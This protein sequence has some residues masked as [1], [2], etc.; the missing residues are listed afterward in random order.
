MSARHLLLF[1]NDYRGLSG[2]VT[3]VALV[4]LLHMIQPLPALAVPALENESVVVGEVL[5]RDIVYS[6]TLKIQPPQRLV[7]LKL[8]IVS[9]D[10]VAGADN[11]LGGQEGKTVEVYSNEVNAPGGAEKQVKLRISFYGDERM[12]RYWIVGTGETKS[13]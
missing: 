4:A 9:V 2:I 12:G 7:R 8:L 13:K 5:A 11:V 1:G 3:L 10:S 6:S